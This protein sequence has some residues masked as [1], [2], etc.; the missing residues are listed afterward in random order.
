MIFW[1]CTL[2]LGQR[3]KGVGGWEEG[4][5]GGK[6]TLG[7]LGVLLGGHRQSLPSNQTKEISF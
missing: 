7:H 6:T 2:I 5:V 3:S 4:R 1:W